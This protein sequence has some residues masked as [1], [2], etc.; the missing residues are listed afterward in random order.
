MSRI[1]TPASIDDSP[2]GSRE[3]LEGVRQQLGSVPNLFRIVGTSP[4]AL[5]G[6]TSV[7]RV[8]YRCVDHGAPRR[9]AFTL[10][11]RVRAEVTP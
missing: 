2:A 1:P 4:A 10:L 11:R 5:E 6:Y 7:V 8:P 9:G 3:L